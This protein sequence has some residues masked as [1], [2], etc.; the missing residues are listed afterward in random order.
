M[1]RSNY[2]NRGIKA[3]W[4]KKTRKGKRRLSARIVAVYGRRPKG[5]GQTKFV[6]RGKYFVKV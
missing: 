3:N 6:R 5:K 2:W 1:T 4:C